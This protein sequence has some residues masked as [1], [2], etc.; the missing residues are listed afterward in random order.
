MPVE[1]VRTKLGS[2]RYVIS[3]RLEACC[4]VIEWWY[5]VGRGKKPDDFEERLEQEAESRARCCIAQDCCSGEL[6]YCDGEKE[7]RGWW[8]IV[9]D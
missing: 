1:C 5:D 3:G 6:N 7:W 2:R 4:H 8:K 9:T